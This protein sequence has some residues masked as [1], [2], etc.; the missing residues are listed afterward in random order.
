MASDTEELWQDELIWVAFDNIIKYIKTL[1]DQYLFPAL[2]SEALNFFTWKWI[3]TEGVN[4]SQRRTKQ[5]QGSISILT[6]FLDC[7]LHSGTN[8][9]RIG[10]LFAEK[11]RLRHIR[12]L[13]CVEEKAHTKMVNPAVEFSRRV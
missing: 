10:A 13:V 11:K 7:L 3:S 9:Y 12:L 5:D 6:S 1:L 8:I 2:L 4:S